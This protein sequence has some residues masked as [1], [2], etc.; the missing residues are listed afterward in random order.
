M[1]KNTL[2][3]FILLLI[4]GLN[5]SGNYLDIVPRNSHGKGCLCQSPVPH[6][7]IYIPATDIFLSQTWFSHVWTLPVTKRSARFPKVT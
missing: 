5:T 2:Y 6:C 1:K 7:D 3:L 4:T